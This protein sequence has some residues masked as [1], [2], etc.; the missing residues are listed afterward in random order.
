MPQLQYSTE[1]HK[2][3]L[4][5]SKYTLPESITFGK[6]KLLIGETGDK[7]FQRACI[8]E[9][10]AMLFFVVICCGCAMVT[11]NLEHPNLMM[12][13]ASFGFGIMCL[14]QFVGPLS[15]GHINCAVSFALFI[16][17][18]ISFVRCVCYTFSQMFGAIWGAI[19]LLM[20]FGNRWPAARA[21]GSN[22]WD[23]TVFSGGQVFFAEMLGTML[24]GK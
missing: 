22:S 18:R 23:E 11:L 17:G 21:F 24:L 1:R 12:V 19:F 14:A 5:P 6:V 13:A 20:I 15:G 2:I 10:I 8:A 16:A 9:F 4:L 3:P 7:K